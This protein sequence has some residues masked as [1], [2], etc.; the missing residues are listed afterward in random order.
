MQNA[1]MDSAMQ[2]RQ[3]PTVPNAMSCI[4]QTGTLMFLWHQLF[5]TVYKNATCNFWLRE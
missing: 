5:Q 2:E 1:L 4:G 3:R